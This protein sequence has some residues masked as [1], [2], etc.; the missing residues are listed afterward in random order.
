MEIT[1]LDSLSP[2]ELSYFSW[3]NVLKANPCCKYMLEFSSFFFF[4]KA[5][6]YSIVYIPYVY[7]TPSSVVGC[8]GC[9]HHAAIVNSA[10]V[11]IG[12][13]FL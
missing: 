9:F 3:H 13:L 11:I 8:L 1:S 12:V 7:F 5:E 4:F 2:L 10:A 6:Y